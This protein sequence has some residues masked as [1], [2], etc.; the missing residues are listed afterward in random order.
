M[1]N[2]KAKQHAP[3][4]T[5]V[6]LF[7]SHLHDIFRHGREC[8]VDDSRGNLLLPVPVDRGDPRRRLDQLGQTEVVG[9]V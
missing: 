2:A 9:G 4:I 1:Q 5:D 8:Q 3:V 6:V 7:D